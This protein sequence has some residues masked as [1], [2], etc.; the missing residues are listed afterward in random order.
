M[1]LVDQ[2]IYSEHLFIFAYVVCIDYGCRKEAR[3]LIYCRIISNVRRNNMFED[4]H[5]LR[6]VGLMLGWG[7]LGSG[8]GKNLCYCFIFNGNVKCGKMGEGRELLDEK[9]VKDVLVWTTLVSGYDQWGDLESANEMLEKNQLCS[10]VCACASI[11]SL[12]HGRQIHACLIQTNFR[13]NMIVVSSLVDMYSKCDCLKVGKWN[14]GLTHNKQCRGSE[15][16]DNMVK[17]GVK[18]DRTGPLLLLWYFQCISFDYGILSDQQHYTCLID[19]LARRMLFANLSASAQFDQQG[20]GEKKHLYSKKSLYVLLSS[21]YGAIGKWELVEKIRHLM[22]KRQVK[23]KVDFST[24]W[25]GTE[26][27]KDQQTT[28]F[29][30]MSDSHT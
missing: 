2:T 10:C 27:V 9:K 23:K 25:G 28:S 15:M 11:A 29:D 14:F 4:K 26:N 21:I 5:E 7:D 6:L 30:R 19:L 18:P 22:D 1:T 12:P 13:P 20:E 17:M 8:R 24:K 16:F 3:F